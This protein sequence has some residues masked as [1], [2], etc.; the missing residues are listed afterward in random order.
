MKK[1]INNIEKNGGNDNDI[2][3]EE[4]T[5]EQN[6]RVKSEMSYFYLDCYWCNTCGQIHNLIDLRTY[7]DVEFFNIIQKLLDRYAEK[8]N[9]KKIMVSA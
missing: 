4:P 5:E 2:I 8:K 1:I 6:A 9:L 3:R 7:D